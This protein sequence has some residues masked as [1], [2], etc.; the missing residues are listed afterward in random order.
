MIRSEILPTPRIRLAQ[1][2]CD[3]GLIE[4]NLS[5]VL[6]AIQA[7]A[8]HIDLL[9]MPETCLQGFPT[10]QNIGQLALQEDSA[11]IRR[12]LKAARD[13]ELSVAFGFAEVDGGR[14]FNTAILA[15]KDG[16]VLLKYRKTHLYK[17]DDGVFEAGICYP[18]CQWQGW[19]VGLLICFDIEFPEAARALA[20]QGAQ[21]I[22]VPDGNMD[23]SALVHSAM[24]P[25][26]AMENQLFI[27]M[28]NRAGAG[29]QYTFAGESQIADPS[30]V[31]LAKGDSLKAQCIDIS[32]DIRRI[33]QERKELRYL[34][35][36]NPI[37][38]ATKSTPSALHPLPQ[39]Q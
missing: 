35:L 15:D 17:S 5:R 16:R 34:S 27:A 32:I 25:V 8:G 7:G 3:D 6:D 12:V 26:R 33:E 38:M 23:F 4:P 37:V 11:T 28:C 29:A 13:A 21:L 22:V 9:I 30:G 24:I 36:I 39:R 18:V 2:E 20:L 14:F 19:T 1:M 31:T 10:S